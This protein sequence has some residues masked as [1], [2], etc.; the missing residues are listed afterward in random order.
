MPKASSPLKVIHNRVF[1]LGFGLFFLGVVGSIFYLQQ[2][3]HSQI[4]NLISDQALAVV[5]VKLNRQ[6]LDF[7]ETQFGRDSN[8]PLNLPGVRADFT[9]NDFTPWL[10]HNVVFSWLPNQQFI[11]AF[12]YRNRQK[13]RAFINTFLL[14]E[15]TMAQQASE[16]GIIFTPSYSSNNAFLFYKGWLLWG[17]NVMTLTQE[18]ATPNKLN[19]AK[20]YNGLQKDLPH[21]KFIKAYFNFA[22]DT[23]ALTKDSKNQSY[24]PLLRGLGSSTPQWGLA[25][26]LKGRQLRGDLKV[27]THQAVFDEN[28]VVA[29]PTNKTL[30]NLA[31]YAPKNALF[32]QNGNDLYA[33]YLH[34]K[35]YLNELDPQLALVF[36]GLIRAQAENW[37][38]VD[39]D[40]ETDFLP[41]IRGPYAFMLDFNQGLEIGFISTLGSTQDSSSINQ[42]IQKAQSRFTPITEEVKLPDGST[43]L[44]LIA[45]DPQNLPIKQ[46]QLGDQV[47]YSF[48]QE[49]GSINFSYTQIGDY[50][51]MAN[52]VN[53]IEKIISTQNKPHPSLATNQDFKDSVLYEFGTAEV[54][55]FLNAAKINQLLFYW[56]EMQTLTTP[57][58][59]VWLQNLRNITFSR[60]VFPEAMYL[61]LRVFFNEH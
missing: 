16:F 14:P 41:L 40:F 45:S 28:E 24:A 20:A 18:L 37:F 58:N 31:F 43:R 57:F 60:Q 29:K 4:D 49:D 42:L 10:H 8:P 27:I 7:L 21:L 30:P 33:K 53:L 61:K 11:Y 48:S 19:Q 39:F 3:R 44:E 22:G 51:V 17:D 34:T 47:Y 52:R 26:N 54:Y 46:N 35:K 6:N 25:L 9:I 5:E 23:T 32:F 50:L 36:E 59:L 38:G 2:Y 15:E 13:A 1:F 12:K 55:G 56:Q